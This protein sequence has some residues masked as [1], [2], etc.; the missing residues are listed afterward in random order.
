M[1]H[2]ISL[3][4]LI[5]SMYNMNPSVVLSV[6]EV[7]S[8]FHPD[9]VGSQGEIGLMQIRPEYASYSREALFNPAI[10]IMV[11]VEQLARDRATC[12][13]KRDHSYVVCFNLGVA[14]G[15][16]LKYPQLFPYYRKVSEAMRKYQ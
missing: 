16:K 11:G 12:K 14:R 1:E 2:I 8:Q 10:N 3:V 15:N 4:L 5:S 9:A 6:I 13:H 7:E